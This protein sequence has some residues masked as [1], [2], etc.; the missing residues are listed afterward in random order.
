[1]KQVFHPWTEWECYHAGMYDGKTALS[2]DEAKAAY[3]TFL[4]DIPRFNAAMERVVNE[5]PKS[6]EH[7][8]T[9]PNINRI[10]WLG[11]AAMCIDTGV[12]RKHRSGFMLMSQDECKAANMAAQDVLTKWTD[13]RQD[14]E[15]HQRVEAP[16]LFG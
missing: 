11:Q 6:C 16:G 5:W 12:S 13:A 9:N 7:F 14:R 15:V 4:R 1:M 3:A 10:A 2:M 8:L